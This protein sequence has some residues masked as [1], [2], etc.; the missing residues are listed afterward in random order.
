[1]VQLVLRSGEPVDLLPNLRVPLG[2]GLL[3]DPPGIEDLQLHS[4]MVATGRIQLRKWPFFRYHSRKVLRH[5]V[6]VQKYQTW[7]WWARLVNHISLL[8]AEV[9]TFSRPNHRVRCHI[10]PSVLL[11]TMD[12]SKIPLIL[13]YFLLVLIRIIR[14]YQKV[15][16][17]KLH[18]PYLVCQSC[19]V[20]FRI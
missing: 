6:Q 14:R 17:R 10:N 7:T 1:M 4:A 3:V 9:T 12:F 2:L 15:S 20:A 16:F 19:K 8:S 13:F 5:P 18:S 11:C